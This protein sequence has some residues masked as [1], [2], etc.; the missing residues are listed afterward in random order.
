MFIKSRFFTTKIGQCASWAIISVVV[1]LFSINDV[2]GSELY[3]GAE[4]VNITPTL[5]VSLAGQMRMRIAEEVETPLTGSIVLLENINGNKSEISIWISMELVV[6][7]DELRDRIRNRVGKLIPE[8]NPEKIIINATHTHTGPSTRK[9][10]FILPENVLSVEETLDFLSERIS[11]GVVSAWKSRSNGSV[12][13]G[14]GEAKLGMNR[15][16]VYYDGSARMYGSTD[17]PEFKGL[18]GYEDHS[19][20]ILYFWNDNDKLIASCINVACPAQEVEGRSK[21]NADFWY[22]V[23]SQL[24]EKFN[25]DLVVLGWI[26]AAGD[27]SPHLMYGEKSDSRMRSLRGLTRL[28]ELARKI[29][30]TVEDV[31]HVVKEDRY[32]DITMHHEVKQLSLPKRLVTVE[33]VGEAKKAIQEIASDSVKKILNYRRI[34]WHQSILDRYK[35]Q[36]DDPD[37]TYDIEIH[38]VRLGDVAICTNPFELFTEYG[39]RIKSRSPALQTFVIQLAG[40][41]TY[42][43]T[44]KAVKGGHY[45]AIIQSNEVGPEGGDILVESTV[46]E[47]SNFWE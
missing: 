40:S 5:P 45:S 34:K 20:N 36:Q 9:G 13:W 44:M 18:E 21:V 19:V 16:A 47:L 6:I 30:V 22:P 8:V 27:Q 12:T 46:R 29:V 31:Y 33:S 25:E 26:G 43:P 3:I 41:G 1:V 14:V 23:R 10:L 38:V 7:T 2:E 17:I 11:G 15:R 35:L 39:I 24:R 28:E 32:S 4:S 37:D 42:L